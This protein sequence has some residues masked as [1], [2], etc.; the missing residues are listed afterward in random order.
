VQ[1][2]SDYKGEVSVSMAPWPQVRWSAPRVQWA[3][4]W[5]QGRNLLLAPPA[6]QSYLGIHIAE[7]SAERAR[8]LKMNEPYGVEVM[9]VA[10][11]SPAEKAGLRKGDAV[12]RYQG[13]RVE[14]GQQFARFV[15]ETPAGRSVS[16]T[17]L[18]E[19]AEQDLQVEVGER[20]AAASAVFNC[21]E[22]PCEIHI[23][24]INLRALDFD[25]PK[26]LMVTQSRSLGAEI[27]SLDGQLAE[28]FGV[29]A[30]LLVRS[31]RTDSPASRAGLQAGDVIVEA[32]GKAL[33][34]TGDLRSGLAA[35]PAGQQIVLAVVRNKSRISLQLEPQ[36]T[37]AA[38]AR[39]TR[40]VRDSQ[41]L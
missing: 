17:V 9:S 7:I 26:P 30:G 18:R 40:R 41:R 2:T 27:E 10:Q 33:K 21:G 4:N 28:H 24:A 16:L 39:G 31:V 29:S 15:R 5:P 19:G 36:R 37:E 11:G 32:A 25:L 12:L 34:D 3:Q 23:P 14:G 38:P 22:E 6:G 20:R 8:E 13:Q 35:A 1:W